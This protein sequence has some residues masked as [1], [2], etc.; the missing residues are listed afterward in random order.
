MVVEF[1]WNR[2]RFCGSTLTEVPFS[3]PGG[4]TAEMEDRKGRVS[5]LYFSNQNTSFLG[6]RNESDTKQF[7][8]GC[9][10]MH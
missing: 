2:K 5:L 3:L 8:P 1:F 9:L 6:N 10:N 7:M 4:K